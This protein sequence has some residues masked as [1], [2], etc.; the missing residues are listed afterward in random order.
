MCTVRCL[1]CVDC[2]LLLVVRRCCCLVFGVWCLL[3]AVRRLSL[4][5][6]CVGRCLPT[7]VRCLRIVAVV[8][9]LLHVASK[10]HVVVC[11]L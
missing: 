3:F 4:L 9:W 8:C 6:V 10:V 7:V 2:C 11:K 5:F 1:L